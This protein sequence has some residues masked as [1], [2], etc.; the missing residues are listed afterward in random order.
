MK[1]GCG[2]AAALLLEGL[3]LCADRFA[4]L[5]SSTSKLFRQAFVA[6]HEVVKSQNPARLEIVPTFP[7]PTRLGLRN[8]SQ[9]SAVIPLFP[10]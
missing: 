8:H 1:K 6:C 9:I 4:S 5:G 10:E 2:I 7:D 3:S